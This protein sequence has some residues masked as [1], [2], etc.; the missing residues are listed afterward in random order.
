[1]SVK[2]FPFTFD[3]G[4]GFG[5]SEF[6]LLQRNSGVRMR[7]YGKEGETDHRF[8]IEG[9]TLDLCDCL[10]GCFGGGHANESLSSHSNTGMS[11]NVQYGPVLLE[12]SLERLLHHC[13]A[14]P[15]V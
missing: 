4:I 8:A 6:D 7:N 14:T 1:M 15:S 12:Q 5:S 11:D 13:V 10:G 3:D 9:E 2:V